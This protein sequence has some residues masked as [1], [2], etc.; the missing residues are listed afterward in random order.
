MLQIGSI[1]DGKYKILN[2]IG[3]GGMS[4]VYLAMN[5]RANKQWAIKEVRKDGVQNFEVVKQGLI[6]ETDL[7]KKLNHP[8]LPSIIDVIDGDG[9]FLIVMDYIEGKSLSSILKE[10]GAQSQEDVIDWSKQMCDV[11]GYLHSRQPP[12]IYRDMKPAN[13]MLKPDGKVMLI[14]F[15]TAREFKE[16][17]VAD[18]TC[19]GTQG[20]AAPEQYGGHGQ[21]DAR[22]DIYCLGA[23]MYHLLTGHNPS[24]PPYEM[25][26]IR[27]WNPELSSGLEEIV[28]KCTQRNPKDRYQSCAELMYALE[29]YNELDIEFKRAQNRRWRAFLTTASMAVAL[30]IGA[31]GFKTAEN[32]TTSSTYDAYLKEAASLA[33]T[34]PEESVSYYTNAINLN[35]SRGEAYEELL[36]FFLW[37]KNDTGDAG[38]DTGNAAATC[39]FDS[40]EEQEIR[41]AL[42]ISGDSSRSNEE[43]LEANTD[44]YNKF[45]YDLG[46]AYFYSYQGTGNKAASLKWLGIASEAD[47]TADLNERNIQRAANLYKIADYYDSLGVRN[48]AGDSMVSFSDYWYDLTNMVHQE[49]ETRDNNVNMLLI[50][51]EATSQV[52]SKAAE[53]KNAGITREQMEEELSQIRES[54][55]QMEIL[56]GTANA[57]YEEELRQTVQNNVTLAENNLEAVF[58]TGNIGQGGNDDAADSAEN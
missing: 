1:V 50:F 13:I 33:T 18:T 54:L 3:Q 49:M 39:V 32:T 30:G 31:V 22:T 51:K 47:P 53:F 45:A 10:Y 6:A 27:Y 56:T 55:D 58:N 43:Y 34:D 24:E 48:Q 38:L 2:K 15:G 26:P 19:L 14:D 42:G 17:S 8:N 52:F 12:I 46:I 4:V 11:L 40:E 28:L 20:Y 23:T 29:H 41:R 16:K 37:Q 36:N 9:T 44:D 21:T 57:E 7:L 35:P 5:E 25:Y